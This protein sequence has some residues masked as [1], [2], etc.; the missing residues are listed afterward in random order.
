MLSIGIEKGKPFAP[1]AHM[2]QLLAEAA[3][4][5]GAIARARA[6]GPLAADVYYYPGKQWQS[7]GEKGVDY[8]FSRNGAPLIDAK[9]NTYY[10]AAGNSPGMMDKNVGQGSQYLWTYRD[11]EG[12]YLDG[13]K[14]YT[15]HIAPNIPMENFWSVVVYDPLSRSQLQTGQRLPSVSQYSSPI[16]NADGSIDITFGPTKPSGKANWI[17]TVPGK[18]FFPMFRFYSP[19]EA[20]FDKSWQLEDVKEVTAKAA[21]GG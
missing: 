18:G 17:E 16:V 3:Q 7:F 20:Y 9:I 11:A 12:N 21:T 6:Y 5:G 4:L 19:K 1:D 14:T 13:G 8:T 10:M 15:L 2:K